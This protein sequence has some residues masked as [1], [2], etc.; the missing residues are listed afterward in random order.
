MSRVN[1]K[2]AAPGRQSSTRARGRVAP[3]GAPASVAPGRVGESAAASRRAFEGRIPVAEPDETK[4]RLLDAL[5]DCE[6]GAFVHNLIERS[7]LTESQIRNGLRR[8]V[9][10]RLVEERPAQLVATT[11]KFRTVY[12]LT[13]RGRIW[14]M[15]GLQRKA[16]GLP[17]WVAGQGKRGQRGNMATTPSPD[18]QAAAT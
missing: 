6:H 2:D 5:A 3:A 1:G 12:K 7:G 17:V 16:A 8:A 15:W 9:H 18:G 4:L 14:L 11:G 10:L 13:D